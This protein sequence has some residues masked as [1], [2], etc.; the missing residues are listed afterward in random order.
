MSTKTKKEEKVNSLVEEMISGQKE[1]K[2]CLHD[3]VNAL[4]SPMKVGISEVMEKKVF[5]KSEF[6]SLMNQIWPKVMSEEQWAEM[7]KKVEEHEES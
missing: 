5:S 4:I 6:D 3:I 1:E 2:F 7:I